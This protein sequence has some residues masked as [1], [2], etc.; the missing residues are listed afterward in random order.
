[1]WSTVKALTFNIGAALAPIVTNLADQLSELVGKVIHFVRAN[2]GAIGVVAIIAVAVGAVG[3]ALVG[4]GG[5]LHLASLGTV[6]LGT[7]WAATTATMLFLP[8]TLGRIVRSVAGTLSGMVTDARKTVNGWSAAWT[9]AQKAF[10]SWHKQV[11]ARAATIKATL[12]PL[13]AGAAAVGQR[14]V[15]SLTRAAEFAFGQL[16]QAAR[17]AALGV[18]ASFRWVAATA[19]GVWSRVDATARTVF[20][21]LGQYATAAAPL[22]QGATDAI[23][24]RVTAAWQSV[25]QRVS[26]ITTPIQTRIV[27]AW[28]TIGARVSATVTQLQ[29]RITSTWANVSSR[30]SSAANS[31]WSQV[32]SVAA[33]ESER[34]RSAVNRA[35]AS[36]TTYAAQQW[37]RVASA[38]QQVASRVTAT[39]QRLPA[40]V[41]EPLARIASMAGQDAR[42][43]TV[44]IRA[45]FA[46]VPGIASAAWQQVRGV[47]VRAATSVAGVTRSVMQ[48]AFAMTQ[49]AGA[50]AFGRVRRAGIG[51]MRSV[52]STGAAAPGKMLGA[53]ASVGAALTM[54]LPGAGGV[55]GT[56]LTALP[57]IA[58]A[59]GA[60]GAALLSLLT[61]VGLVA[62]AVIGGI[63]AW[64][65][66]TTE[67]QQTLG[68]L[69]QVFGSLWQVTSKVLGGLGDA[70]AAGDMQLAARILWAGLKAIW[71][72]GIDELNKVWPT[73][74]SAASAVWQQISQIAATAATYVAGIWAQ[75]PQWLTGPL[76]SIGQVF[77][78][79]L[80]W[81]GEQFTQLAAWAGETFSAIGAALAQGDFAL[82]GEIA[83]VSIK[84]AFAQ[85][86]AWVTNAWTEFTT[87]LS[88]IWDGMVTY[89]RQ[90]WNDVVSW[91]AKSILQLVG[92]V[93]SALDTISKY[94]PTGLADKLKQQM[95]VDVEGAIRTVEEDRARYNQS[96]DVAKGQRDDERVRAMQDQLAA[97]EAQL[98]ELRAAREAALAKSRAAADKAGPAGSPLAKAMNELEKALDD[99]ANAKKRLFDPAAADQQMTGVGDL[100]SQFA[101]T[102]SLAG[103]FSASVAAMLGRSGD[104]PAERTAE[105]VESMDGTLTDIRD[106]LRGRPMLAFDE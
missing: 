52:L 101:S 30:V 22:I 18:S 2:Q 27:S 1:M 105:A 86:I 71:Y 64:T 5:A 17:Q 11:A 44:L 49:A 14:M 65:A 79:A 36:M 25:A 34:A 35:Y 92:S 6:A 46:Q 87:G 8:R 62:A 33:R 78:T 100:T 89:L 28:Q 59:V 90:I 50:A 96:Q 45:A 61:P 47:G 10:D 102:G 57:L 9:R 67:G 41:R 37:Q 82:A 4:L 13:V 3:I 20:A 103:T 88:S 68:A 26:A 38:G 95:S 80:G 70:L 55:V 53:F 32:T 66:W 63:V 84:L 23:T 106:D 72:T 76:A 75:L 48:R 19:P 85:G 69:K 98:A 77:G 94:D 93:Q 40:W 51:A 31:V 91:L 58:S 29:N 7:L 54:L 104:D 42:R 60:V 81:I 21:R 99:A 16:R 12:E 39:W 74:Q 15:A 24:R 83:W 97:T 43:A 73:L 56:L